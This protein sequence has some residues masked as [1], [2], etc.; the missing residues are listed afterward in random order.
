M[1]GATYRLVGPMA[2]H[3]AASSE[4]IFWPPAVLARALLVVFLG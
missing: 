2:V 3:E 4:L 1:S